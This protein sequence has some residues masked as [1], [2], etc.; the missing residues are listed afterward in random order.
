METLT[1]REEMTE[2]L[3]VYSSNGDIGPWYD[4]IESVID[5][6]KCDE[7]FS[8]EPGEDVTIYRGERTEYTHT[9]FADFVGENIQELFQEAAWDEASEYADDY[10]GDMTPDH[11]NELTK[12]VVDFLDKNCA[13]PT[14]WTVSDSEPFVMTWPETPKE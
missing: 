7:T 9:D 1:G 5:N 6:L 12:L 8:A 4:N 11:R 13:Q 2:H 3:Y 14:F 10:L